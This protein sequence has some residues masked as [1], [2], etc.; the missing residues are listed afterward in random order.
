MT[1]ERD[2]SRHRVLIL[3]GRGRYEDPW[4]DHAATSHL[5]ARLFDG[6]GLE[7][8]VR[9]LF[10]HVA[11]EISASLYDLVVVNG[12]TGR[13]DPEFDGADEDWLPVHRAIHDYAYAGAPIL[14][15]HQGINAFLDDPEWPRIV[16]GRWVRGTTYHPE[17]SEALFRVVAGSH[18]LTE[19]LADVHVDDERYT[20]LA[21]ADGVTVTTT[22]FEAGAEQPT[23]WVN[24][25]HGLRTI[26]DSL[27]HDAGTFASPERI[28]LLMHEVNWLLGRPLDA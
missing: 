20:L 17:Q 1:V 9:S 18:P 8:T 12:G 22:Q 6:H 5:L 13:I 28:A 4:H 3:A 7:T 14:V 19:G 16:G 27:G 23:S 21:P 2:G 25:S 26:Y 24:T 10:P 15:Y 11:D